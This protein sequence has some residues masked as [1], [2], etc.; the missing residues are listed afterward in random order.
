MNIPQNWI[1]WLRKSPTWTLGFITFVTTL[2]GFVILFR[3]NPSL[4]FVVVATVILIAL[5]LL[6]LFVSFAKTAPLIHGGKGL[7]RFE[8][9]RPLALAGLIIL[10]IFTTVLLA[11][12]GNREYIVTSFIGT[13]TPTPTITPTPTL[14][15]LPTSTATTTPSPT[16]IVFVPTVTPIGWKPLIVGYWQPPCSD[17]FLFLSDDLIPTN[18]NNISYN[19]L[20]SAVDNRKAEW[21]V[22]DLRGWVNF[23]LL[24]SSVVDGKD[25]TQVDNAVKVNVAVISSTVVQMSNAWEDDRGCGGGDERGFT[26]TPLNSEQATY[27]LYRE[28]KEADYFSFQPGEF[29]EFYTPFQCETPGKFSVTFDVLFTFKGEQGIISTDEIRVLC[30]DKY[31]VW[32]WSISESPRRFVESVYIWKDAKYQSEQP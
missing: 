13:A 22:P 6:S 2:V 12:H 23:S 30:P 8:R 21:L 3:D 16:P 5:W 25:W 14:T 24:V 7:Y 10:P 4:V 1:E 11:P 19:E 18:Y 27:S 15:P 20:V 29:E 31:V 28:S 32:N 17:N 26:Q 9:H